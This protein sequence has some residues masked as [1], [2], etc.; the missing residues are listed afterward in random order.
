MEGSAMID[1][2]RAG[3]PDPFAAGGLID[4]R[5]GLDAQYLVT[6]TSVIASVGNGPGMQM[7][8]ERVEPGDASLEKLT[9]INHV[10]HRPESKPGS[11]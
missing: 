10:I 8:L 11:R 4:V 9:E 2:I 3:R 5:Y 7:F 6:P 1:S